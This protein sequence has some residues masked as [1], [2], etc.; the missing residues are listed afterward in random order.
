MVS[1]TCLINLS[2]CG[3][4]VVDI[5]GAPFGIQSMS[6]QEFRRNQQNPSRMTEKQELERKMETLSDIEKQNK[7]DDEIRDNLL[8]EKI[9]RQLQGQKEN[10]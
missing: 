6:D 10:N 9:N 8:N 4:T 3:A 2:G 1:F 7:K 5:I